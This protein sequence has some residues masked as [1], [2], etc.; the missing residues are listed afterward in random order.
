MIKRRQF[1]QASALVFS[2]NV[3][4][5]WLE[6]N[7]AQAAELKLPYQNFNKTQALDLSR[8]SEGLVPGAAQA[9]A[10]HFIDQQLQRDGAE[11]CLLMIR[12]LGVDPPFKPFYLAGLEAAQKAAGEKFNKSLALLSDDELNT[13]ITAMASD[14]LK[15]WQG[16][17]ASFFYFVLRADAVDAKYGTELGFADLAVPYMAH[18]KPKT[19]W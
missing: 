17:P 18:I 10:V 14:A 8:L 1:L 11:N 2:F 15:G 9:G 6:L 13:F 19:A 5:S 3:A 4:G 16:P 7:C 12:Y